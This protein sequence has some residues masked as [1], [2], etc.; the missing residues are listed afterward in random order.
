[1]VENVRIHQGSRS[2]T[3]HA[4]DL[5]RN[6][7]EYRPA[8]TPQ[9]PA[10]L[11]HHKGRQRKCL[12]PYKALIKYTRRRRD[13]SI[14][15]HTDTA[16]TALFISPPPCPWHGDHHRYAFSTGKPQPDMRANA[17]QSRQPTMKVVQQ[18]AAQ[19]MALPVMQHSEF[20]EGESGHGGHPSPHAHA[21][22][23]VQYIPSRVPRFCGFL[24]AMPKAPRMKQAAIF[25]ANVPIWNAPQSGNDRTSVAYAVP[26]CIPQGT[27]RI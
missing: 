13:H 7:R 8:I 18:Y 5:D 2:P 20:L 22:S 17:C 10:I 4:R 19:S 21:T 1:M 3:S 23:T 6:R 11:L 26:R 16:M 27:P 9:N 15:R 25:A 24:P 14:L 12:M